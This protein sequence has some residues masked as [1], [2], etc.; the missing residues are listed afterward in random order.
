MYVAHGYN[1]EIQG[2]ETDLTPACSLPAKPTNVAVNGST[3]TSIT[4]TY[5]TTGEVTCELRGGGRDNL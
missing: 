5:D 1:N 3:T 4:V 2:D